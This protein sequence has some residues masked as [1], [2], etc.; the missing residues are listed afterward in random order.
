MRLSLIGILLLSTVGCT[1]LL[2]LQ[3][4]GVNTGHPLEKTEIGYPYLRVYL[5]KDSAAFDKASVEE[6]WNEF[7]EVLGQDLLDFK[8]CKVFFD[9]AEAEPITVP[10][11]RNSEKIRCIGVLVLLPKREDTGPRKLLLTKSDLSRVLRVTW[12]RIEF[13]P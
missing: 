7:R 8:G 12:S 6:L 3:V 13:E 11:G 10:L 4:R 1:N 9:G 2:E 5:L